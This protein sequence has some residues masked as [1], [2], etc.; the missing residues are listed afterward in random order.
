MHGVTIK[1]KYTQVAIV[2][3]IF[4]LCAITVINFWQQAKVYTNQIIAEDITVLS[5]VFN[6]IHHDCIIIDFQYQQQNYIDF[7]NVISFEGSEI[8]T[9]HLKY[10]HH[11]KGPYMRENPTIQG[12][13]YQ[14]VKTNMGFYIVP[15]N[16]VQLNNGKII[17]KDILL[18][19]KANINAM[20]QD[21]GILN[22]NG[23]PLAAYL[24]LSAKSLILNDAVD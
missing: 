3:L 15:G 14:I 20:I 6:S 5:T 12:K 19:G 16:G 17:G 9:M 23:Q 2:G 22:F 7:L 21:K 10:P 11:W 24:D 13:Y 1:Q 18:D 4:I 8:G